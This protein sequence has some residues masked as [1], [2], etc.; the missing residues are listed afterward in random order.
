[1][2]TTAIKTLEYLLAD[3]QFEIDRLRKEHQKWLDEQSANLAKGGI[4]LAYGFEWADTAIANTV[5]LEVV[6]TMLAWLDE[7]SLTDYPVAELEAEA[8][9]RLKLLAT[10]CMK[11]ALEGA[12]SPCRSTSAMS[13]LIAELRTEVWA[14]QISGFSA[15]LAKWL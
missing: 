11:K 10:E 8:A 7:A 13:R 1:M 6:E 15:R 4:S 3:F 14:G 9:R 12:R 5:K 2:T